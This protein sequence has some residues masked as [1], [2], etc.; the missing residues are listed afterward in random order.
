[1]M[2]RVARQSAQVAE[3]LT[4]DGGDRYGL[5]EDI[6]SPYSAKLR[7][8]LHYRAIP[9]ARLRATMPAWLEHIP[10]QVGFPILPVMIHPDGRVLQDST[11]MIAFLETEEADHPRAAPEDLGLAFVDRLLE[12]VADEHLPRLIMHTRW[13][14]EAARQTMGRRLARRL[15]WGVPDT[16]L[17]AATAFVV[18]RQSGFDQPLAL[19]PEHREAANAEIVEV[20][21]LLDAHLARFGYL[22]GDRPS[23][24]DFAFYGPVWAHWFRDPA[25]APLVEAHGPN[26]IAWLDDLTDLGDA[27]GGR[28]GQVRDRMGDHATLE[29]LWPT[30]SPLLRY[31]AETWLPIGVAFGPV[32]AARGKRVSVE[33]RGTTME[34]ACHHYRA[35]AFHEVQ[36]DWLG[37]PEAVRAE[38][39]PRLEEVGLLPD[40]VAHG[41]HDNGLYA[42][43]TPPVIVDGVGDARVRHRRQKSG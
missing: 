9:Y 32:S 38:L 15:T 17:D 37:Q 20:L 26:V 35:W 4:F 7:A 5:W 25:S 34:M 13:G 33:V 28:D 29:A 10:K 8:Y 19:G 6:T 31:A 41:L 43:L 36:V 27:R 39:T 24:C 16:D 11:P 23:R 21:Q 42:G 1:M 18:Q 22:L 3:Q 30:L 12:D 14:T 40:L 2:T